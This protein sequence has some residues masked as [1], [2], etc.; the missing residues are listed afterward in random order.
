MFRLPLGR[1]ATINLVRQSRSN[2]CP[3]ESGVGESLVNLFKNSQFHWVF[4]TVNFTNIKIKFKPIYLGG[5][6]R[7][8]DSPSYTSVLSKMNSKRS[9]KE[10][11]NATGE[12]P[13]SPV[14]VRADPQ[15]L[16]PSEGAVNAA[17]LRSDSTTQMDIT[18]LSSSEGFSYGRINVRQPAVNEYWDPTTWQTKPIVQDV[19]YDNAKEIEKVVYYESALANV[20]NES[21]ESRHYRNW[22]LY[23]R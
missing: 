22:N 21:N 3:V 7:L 10:A 8:F 17:K 12:H 19:V 23:L 6:N 18:A 20:F 14:F 1:S 4:V 9:E 15:K 5:V 2:F 13:K 16:I 11:R